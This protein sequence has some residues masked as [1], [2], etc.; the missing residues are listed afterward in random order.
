MS[1]DIIEESNT[2]RTIIPTK[3]TDVRKV[4]LEG[5]NS[6]IQNLPTPFIHKCDDNHAYVKVEDVIKHFFVFGHEPELLSIIKSN[7]NHTTSYPS[8]SKGAQRIAQKIIMMPNHEMKEASVLIA[9]WHDDFEPNTQSKQNR[10][11]VWILSITIL[12]KK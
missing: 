7:H 9:D 10:G 1:E 3:L 8:E 5:K 11:S 12:S 2:I 4:Y 6:L